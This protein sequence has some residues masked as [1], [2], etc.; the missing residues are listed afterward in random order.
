[1]DSIAAKILIP[2]IK[3]YHKIIR[4]ETSLQITWIVSKNN[5]T[6]MRLSYL[7]TG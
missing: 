1:M 2:Y 3:Q 4:D 6:I 7:F 5:A